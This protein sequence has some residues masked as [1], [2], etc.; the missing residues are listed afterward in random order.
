MTLGETGDLNSLYHSYQFSRLYCQKPI[1]VGT[2]LVESLSSYIARLAEAHSMTVASLI[3]EVC[4]KYDQRT[5]NERARKINSF[6][7]SSV[8]T[9][10]TLEGLTLRND[11]KPL[12]MYIWQ[13][14]FAPK[15]MFRKSLAWCPDCYMEMILKNKIIYNP[16]IWHFKATVLCLRHMKPLISQCPNC[17]SNVK[18]LGGGKVGFCTKCNVFLG[19]VS[20][21]TNNVL[22]DY[23]I[24]AVNNIGHLLCYIP[25]NPVQSD[26]L[27]S[28]LNRLTDLML[29][30][31]IQQ[32]FDVS[33][34]SVRD[35][36]SQLHKP[37]INPLLKVCYSI[38]STLRDFVTTDVIIPKE[39]IKVTSKEQKTNSIFDVIYVERYLK[40]VLEKGT[41]LSQADLRKAL[42]YDHRTIRKHFPEYCLSLQERY[43]EKLIRDED[44]MMR[45]IEFAAQT[46]CSLGVKPTKCT[47]AKFIGKDKNIF[48]NNKFI[49][50]LQNINT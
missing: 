11:L 21:N 45:K 47:V 3:K 16:L 41:V 29:T 7:L 14:V 27:V 24:F 2:P 20:E 40:N 25:E 50:I 46:L 32:I 22:S 33:R 37:S 34:N 30:K 23:D 17:R 26:Y 28:N 1:G 12:S 36:E 10:Q 6:S 4:P 18:I 39:L 31:E 42:G 49:A 9:T 38:Q 19:R 15:E 5:F 44:H 48:N 35:W 43:K 8:E 13:N